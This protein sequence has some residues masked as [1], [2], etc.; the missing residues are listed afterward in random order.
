MRIL[1]DAADA[2]APVAKRVIVQNSKQ[3]ERQAWLA[4]FNDIW[5][6]RQLKKTGVHLLRPP[7]IE[8]KNTFANAAI[9]NIRRAVQFLNR[10]ISRNVGWKARQ[11]IL[12][13]IIYLSEPGISS[14]AAKRE[15]PGTGDH[16]TSQ[17]AKRRK[18][19]NE[20]DDVTYW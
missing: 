6:V 4:I 9:N 12:T 20:T 2:S 1:H 7:D 16:A 17:A 8:S 11:S 13:V 15:L 5:G 3:T 18:T 19:A 10:H 14:S